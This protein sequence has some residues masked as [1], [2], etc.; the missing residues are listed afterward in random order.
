MGR[1]WKRKLV[2]NAEN[3][4]NQG[5]ELDNITCVDC[6][7]PNSS[8]LKTESETSTIRSIQQTSKQSEKY[9]EKKKSYP[10]RYDNIN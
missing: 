8:L 2:N 3:A 6:N 7:N 1:A 5:F 9:N 10:F 4:L